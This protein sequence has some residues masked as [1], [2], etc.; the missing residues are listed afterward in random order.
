[1]SAR[2]QAAL[3]RAIAG[4]EL[5]FD[6]TAA[7]DSAPAGC[8]SCDDPQP[9]SPITHNAAPTFTPSWI[10]R[11]PR[12]ICTF[13]IG[14]SNHSSFTVISQLI[15]RHPVLRVRTFLYSG[16]DSGGSFAAGRRLSTAGRMFPGQ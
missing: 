1:M 3:A 11:R 12:V 7:V 8:D 5:G 16:H 4:R 6:E 10:A 2:V 15:D 13:D 14:P 9:A